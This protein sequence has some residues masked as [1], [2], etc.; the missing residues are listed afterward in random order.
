[1]PFHHGTSETDA[2]SQAS[3]H[4]AAP[5]DK[6]GLATITVVRNEVGQPP[7]FPGQANEKFKDNADEAIQA[8][9]DV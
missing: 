6:I 3:L 8:L 2:A 9:R 1:M 5:T 7:F 4:R